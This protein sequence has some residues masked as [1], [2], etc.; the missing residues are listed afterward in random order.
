[1]QSI[2]FSELGVLLG[3]SSESAEAT[4]GKMIAQNRLH[5]SIDQLN[6]LVHFERQGRNAIIAWDYQIENLCSYV[7]YIL[8]A[9]SKAK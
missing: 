4:A 3:A 5:G 2:T 6:K 1:V 7:N 9:T 8:D